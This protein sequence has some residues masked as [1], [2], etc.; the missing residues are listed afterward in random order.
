MLGTKDCMKHAAKLKLEVPMP[1]L[2]KAKVVLGSHV[3]KKH[4]YGLR[5]F[6]KPRAVRRYLPRKQ[7]ELV[8]DQLPEDI[9]HGL[10]AANLSE[11]RLLAPHVHTDEKAVINFY[12]E[13]NEE[14][15]TFWDGEII[16]DDSDVADNG[17]GYLNLRRDALTE[18]EHFV[19]QPGDVWLIDT[20][21]PHSVSYINDE[22]DAELHYEPRDEQKRLIMQAFFSIPFSVVRDSLRDKVVS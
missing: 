16:S 21:F 6:D 15:T 1:F 18:C 3:I 22:R 14:K 19:A 17:N 8:R 11:M 5:G 10:V 12:L 13:T 20:R 7:T 9:K 2:G 4:G